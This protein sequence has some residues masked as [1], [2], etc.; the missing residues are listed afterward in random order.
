[1]TLLENH[2]IILE[3]EDRTM[4]AKSGSGEGRKI[5]LWAIIVGGMAAILAV[6]SF[7][8]QIADVEGQLMERDGLT[9]I[10]LHVDSLFIYLSAMI[11]VTGYIISWWH[12]LPA[13]IL[14]ILAGVFFIVI[15]FLP[16]SLMAP[17]P[18]A[19]SEAGVEVEVEPAFVFG[20]PAL[21]AGALFLWYWWVAEKSI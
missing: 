2:Y 19:A 7:F 3:A 5:G 14:L 13:G 1:M 6:A 21:V 10:A 8:T 11:A 20:I 12:K 17:I 4:A 15:E 9:V 16:D 18:A